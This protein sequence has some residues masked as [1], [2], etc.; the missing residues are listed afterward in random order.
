M[1]VG[2]S[3]FFCFTG[4]FVPST[5]PLAQ[6]KALLVASYELSWPLQQ[7]QEAILKVHGKPFFG[8]IRS[9]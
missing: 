9:L 8:F 3:H 5:L 7:R 4:Q 2:S 6:A 1:S